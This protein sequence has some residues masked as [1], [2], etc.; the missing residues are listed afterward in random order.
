[1][2]RISCQSFFFSRYFSVVLIHLARFTKIIAMKF[3]WINEFSSFIIL[4]FLAHP[5]YIVDIM[6][7]ELKW[8][9]LFVLCSKKWTNEISL[10]IHKF[11][12]LEMLIIFIHRRQT[13][14]ISF[15]G[16]GHGL[17]HYSRLLNWETK[18]FKSFLISGIIVIIDSKLNGKNWPKKY[19]TTNLVK[20][21]NMENCNCKLNTEHRTACYFGV[22][23]SFFLFF[24]FCLFFGTRQLSHLPSPLVIRTM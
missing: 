14:Y 20:M 3:R 7:F 21:W 4:I 9:L 19:T 5:I 17:I 10:Y 6:N 13:F 23:F 18:S 1:M 8:R 22:W 2:F 16:H 12:W 11:K 24:C 15:V